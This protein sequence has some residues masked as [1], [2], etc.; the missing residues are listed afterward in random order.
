M[1]KAQKRT[2]RIV[3]AK[4][5]LASERALVVVVAVPSECEFAVAR[6]WANAPVLA[7]ARTIL[8]GRPGW[9]AGYGR[10]PASEEGGSWLA[11]RGCSSAREER[12]GKFGSGLYAFARSLSSAQS[13]RTPSARCHCHCLCSRGASKALWR[14]LDEAANLRALRSR[15]RNWL[16]QVRAR[17]GGRGGA[18]RGADSA[19][20]LVSL[21]VPQTA[22]PVSGL[23]RVWRRCQA[24]RSQLAACPPAR[25]RPRCT[26]GKAARSRDTLAHIQREQ[27]F[28]A[29]GS[30]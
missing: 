14:P 24:G 27:Q 11:E 2:R 25:P 21:K 28:A 26:A 19:S 3:R 30:L 29:L 4:C 20:E 22:P 12:V 9:R 1:Q 18:R 16:A 5:A 15:G 17:W 23:A 7:L 10:Q 6:S 13:L 8:L